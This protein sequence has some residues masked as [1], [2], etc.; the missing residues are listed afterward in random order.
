MKFLVRKYD[1]III[2][3]LRQ[4]GPLLFIY[5][6]FF[7]SSKIIIEHEQR[8]FG[9][10][11]M[12]KIVS[13]CLY[14]PFL[15]AYWRADLIRSPNVISKNFFNYFMFKKA[16]IV[17]LPLAVLQRPSTNYKRRKSSRVKI[18]WSGKRFWEKSGGLLINL[19][20]EMENTDLTIL[21]SDELDIEHPRIKILPLK[22]KSRFQECALK[23]DLCVYLSPTQ[24]IYDTAAIGLPT[25]VPDQ[26]VPHTLYTK[27]KF[28]NLDLKTDLDG[29]VIETDENYRT[30]KRSIGRLNVKNVGTYNFLAEH[31]WYEYEKKLTSNI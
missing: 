9:K 29:V 26:F 4:I 20:K 31:L 5:T 8:T 28:V 15:L 13:I 10:T 11:I 14:L 17:T 24:S 30:L 16:K 2:S 21:T 12:G 3:D 18:L 7:S 22:N 23:H 25:L 6:K 19:I 1:Y 27:N